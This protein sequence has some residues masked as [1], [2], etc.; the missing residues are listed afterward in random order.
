LTIV[1]VTRDV[2]LSLLV[3][4]VLFT[5]GR[6]LAG[7]SLLGRAALFSQM[8]TVV[9]GLVFHVFESHTVFHT[10][11]PFLLMPVFIITGILAVAAGLHYLYQAIRL[12]Q[13]VEEPLGKQMPV[14]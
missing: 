11:Q 1:L 8:S 10:L 14:Q 7:P 12:L 13:K 2:M 3:G 4:I 5:T 6:R 9:L